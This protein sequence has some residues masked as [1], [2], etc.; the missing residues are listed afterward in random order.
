MVKIK[1]RMRNEKVKCQFCKDTK[2]H[3]IYDGNIKKTITIPCIYC[4]DGG[5][6][7]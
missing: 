6:S 7:K 1:I 4:K 3:Y 2:Y 5:K